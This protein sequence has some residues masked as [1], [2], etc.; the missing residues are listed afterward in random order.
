MLPFE[1]LEELAWHPQCRDEGR[2]GVWHG[3]NA[4]GRTSFSGRGAMWRPYNAAVPKGPAFSFLNYYDRFE[5][6]LPRQGAG[7]EC[8]MAAKIWD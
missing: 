3:G 7:G 8:R 2:I 6:A 4:R 1:A 5:T